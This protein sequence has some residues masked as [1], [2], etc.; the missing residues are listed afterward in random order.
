ML[1]FI[2]SFTLLYLIVSTEN[3][4]HKIIM[5]AYD[6]AAKIRNEALAEINESQ[7][8][9]RQIRYTNKLKD[10]KFIYNN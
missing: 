6:D 1:N 5:N 4:R 7:K 9:I 10:I 8:L 3:K 2:L